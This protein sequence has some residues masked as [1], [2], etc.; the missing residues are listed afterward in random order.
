MERP[1]GLEPATTRL[2]VEV[3]DIFTTD[4]AKEIESGGEHST[5]DRPK[6]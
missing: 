2:T 3:A 1:A 5:L 4:H 6:A